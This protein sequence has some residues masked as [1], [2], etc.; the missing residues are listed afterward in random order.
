[1]K[2]EYKLKIFTI[3]ILFL[4]FVAVLNAN[5]VV[6]YFYNHGYQRDEGNPIYEKIVSGLLIYKAYNREG[7][8]MNLLRLGNKYDGGYIVADDAC[9]ESDVLLGYG[10]DHDISF[11]ES[12]SERYKKP[13]YGFDCGEIGIS[14]K[15]DLFHFIPQCIGTDQFLKTK[16]TSSGNISSFSSQIKTLNL[17]R[18]KIFLK[19]DIEGAEYEV[20]DDILKHN[21]NITSIV[22]EIHFGIRGQETKALDLITR[23]NK[24]FVLVHLHANNCCLEA[25][26]APNADGF[27]SKVLEL[28]YVN[29]R[30]I[31]KYELHENQSHPT[32]LDFPNTSGIG[33]YKFTLIP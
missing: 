8:Q 14:P 19:M 27:V 23:L 26:V 20:F 6:R 17:S 22:L 4:V 28:T 16:S 24:D 33:D 9:K 15:S 12:F 13:S 21:E 29:K 3:T 31:S 7:K 30:L 32:S 10:I 11:E 1:M 18:K 2:H 5:T 25:F